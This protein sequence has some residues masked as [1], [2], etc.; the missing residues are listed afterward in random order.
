MKRCDMGAP[1]GLAMTTPW[2]RLNPSPE[3]PRRP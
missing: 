3:R 2:P 1:R